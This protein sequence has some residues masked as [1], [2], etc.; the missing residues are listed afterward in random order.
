M[1]LLKKFFYEEN[2]TFTLLEI[3]QRVYVFDSCF[4]TD[5]IHGTAEDNKL[6]I[7]TSIANQQQNFPESSS[8]LV[9]SFREGEGGGKA[10][11]SSLLS[12]S[13]M[14][15]V[16]YYPS[17]YAGCPLLPMH[18]IH[19]FLNSTEKWLSAGQHNLLLIHCEPG[20]WP[21]MAFMLAALLV[22]RKQQCTYRTLQS[23]YEQAPRE[24]LLATGSLDPLASQLRYLEYAS[25][26]VG[27]QLPPLNKTLRLDCI[28]L[29]L[30][31]N[32][33]P[34]FRVMGRD[35]FT[36]DDQAP[37]LLFATPGRN[38]HCKKADCQL[39]KVDIGCSVQ[40]DVVMECVSLDNVEEREDMMF[41]VMFHTA[42]VRSK[43]LVL[44]RE[45]IDTLWNSNKDKF[46]KDFRVEV[47]FSEMD[48]STLATSTN[49]LV[50]EKKEC[51]HPKAAS[52]DGG[53]IDPAKQSMIPEPFHDAP[54]KSEEASLLEA[55]LE[56][57]SNEQ[58][59]LCVS[60]K[61]PTPS[62]I[63]SPRIPQSPTPNAVQ[64]SSISVSRYPNAAFS[65]LGITALLHDHASP[66]TDE[67]TRSV[68][69]SPTAPAVSSQVTNLSKLVHLSRS[70]DV[71]QSPPSSQSSVEAPKSTDKA[72]ALSTPKATDD[73]SSTEQSG[74]SIS[75]PKKFRVPSPPPL[76]R[77][78]SKVFRSPLLKFSSPPPPPPPPLSIWKASS[79][80]TATL[81][82]SS[83]PQPPPAPSAKG[84]TKASFGVK[85]VP[86][87]AP[88]PPPL[89][90]S[91]GK[92]RGLSRSR[93]QVQ[94]RKASMKPYHWL[95]L[96]RVTQGSIWAEAQK[97]NDTSMTPEFDILELESLFSSAN[98]ISDM[99]SIGLKSKRRTSVLKTDK[100]QLI[101]L[102]RAYN[103]EIMLTK[104]KIPLHELTSS[105][106]AMD[107]SALDIDQ[108][109]SLVKFCPTKEEMELLKGYK[110]DKESLGKC[111]QFFLELMKVPRVESKLRVFSF[112][113]QFSQQVSDLRR[114][115]N[116][117]NSAAEEACLSFSIFCY[118]L[119]Y[120]IR[121]S[122]KFK[123]IMQ[124]VLSL[125]NTLNQGTAR[126]SAVGFRL[127]SLLKLTDT[128]SR[129]NKIT[130]MHYLCKVL[131]EKLP[132]LL[133]FS[134]DLVSLEAATKVLSLFALIQFKYLAEEM[135]AISKGLEKV[136]QELA[137]SENDGAVSEYFCKILRAF[138]SYAES[139]VKS[140]ASLY[141]NVG[142]NADALALYFGED[143]TR[144]PFEQVVSTLLNFSRMLARAHEENCKR[145]EYEKRKAEKE[146]E[147]QRKVEINGGGDS[148]RE[149]E[150][151]HAIR[152][153]YTR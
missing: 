51:H 47:V 108:V 103:C 93:N 74:P 90:S 101:E 57:K 69:L 73:S 91:G 124:S 87:P 21:A 17:H 133:D 67:C 38:Q 135:Q 143:P 24:L 4:G 15:V 83:M 26:N 114:N 46:P 148:R 10:Q 76:P 5:Q 144:C 80:K 116:V 131:A 56:G 75:K 72:S 32:S 118:F 31:P 48:T 110:G 130:L 145:V 146:A 126:G 53:S 105:V 86:P 92:D 84:L 22:H 99:K 121:S 71:K 117:V 152:S 11:M 64:R 43:V 97:S 40:G 45:Q 3:S 102:R 100:V 60:I 115:L 70:F 137:A 96:T 139:E 127:D 29:K 147:K 128:R 120:H 79:Q 58:Q 142:R 153:R 25:R 106:L 122:T 112:K 81:L 28:I 14:T 54:L 37:K 132:E 82:K 68:T 49:F 113:M 27:S 19:H 111:E 149:P 20:G 33:R 107:D 77:F 89:L 12:E 35:P 6:Y 78:L 85:N 109:D 94:P 23:I 55:S 129:N 59:G 34:V 2:P 44:T 36:D 7:N 66:T 140:L 62:K 50:E 125:G 134:K 95:K 98:P 151:L 61:V 141:S 13:N 41:R 65:G 123:R 39:V 8:F 18:M 136:I 63:I 52:G 138:L 119:I 104:V 1:A 150:M 88:G 16:E 30:V 9:F 42:F